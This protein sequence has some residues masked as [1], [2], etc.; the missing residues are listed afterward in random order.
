MKYFEEEGTDEELN[1]LLSHIANFTAEYHREH[2]KYL[3]KM[4][5]EMKTMF[6]KFAPSKN[7][8]AN[9]NGKK[10]SG[11]NG[12]TEEKMTPV[13]RRR[14]RSI[15]EGHVTHPP[16]VRVIHEPKPLVLDE[17]SG[18]SDSEP[19]FDDVSVDGMSTD[20]GS[21]PPSPSSGVSAAT[22]TRPGIATR[23]A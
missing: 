5:R 21:V 20:G 17:L 10:E 1:V 19:D 16:P 11:A 7:P 12:K 2:L 15:D 6:N 22:S 13:L 14:T 9:G 4:K 18:Q 3:E 23:S 8:V